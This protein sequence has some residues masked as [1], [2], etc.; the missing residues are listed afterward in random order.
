M[1][2]RAVKVL[3]PV[4]QEILVDSGSQTVTLIFAYAGRAKT[5]QRIGTEWYISQ[6]EKFV[7][8]PQGVAVRS[9]LDKQLPELEE[10]Q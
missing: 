6:G 5:Y 9:I 3:E 2:R 4:V 8:L 7:K 10:K 1:P